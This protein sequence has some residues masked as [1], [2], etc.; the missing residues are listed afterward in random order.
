MQQG[1]NKQECPEPQPAPEKYPIINCHTHI[2]TGDSV[3]PYLAKSIVISPFYK[4]FN[5]QLIFWFFRKRL[6]KKAE[7]VFDGTQ[8]LKARSAFEKEKKYK[9]QFFRQ[10]VMFLLSIYLFAWVIDIL[11]HWFFKMPSSPKWLVS[12]LTNSDQVLHMIYLPVKNGFLQFLV[13]VAVFYFFKPSRRLILTL[14]KKGSSLV[15]SIPTKEIKELY[16]R[17]MTIGRFAFH[18]RQRRTLED[19]EKQYPGNT[20]FVI[21]PM[22]MTYM[23]AGTPPVTYAQ[24]MEELAAIRAKKKNIHPFVFADPR[25]MKE[26]PSYFSYEVK[27]G[28]I[29]L[30]DCFVKKYIDG[31]I[32]KNEK[33]EEVG[34]AR[35]SG[36]KIYPALGYFPFDPLL[37]P[38]WKYAQQENLPIMTHCVRG[39]IHYRGKKDEAWDYHP[40]FRELI[41]KIEPEDRKDTPADYTKLLLA[42]KKNTEFTANFTHPMNY[43]CLLKKE[44]LAHAVQIAWSEADAGTKTKLKALFDF[45]PGENDKDPVVNSGLDE[46]K[47]CFGHYGGDDEWQRYFEKDRFRHSSQLVSRPDTGINFLHKVNNKK[48]PEPSLGKPEQLWKFTDWYSIISSLMLQHD[49]VYADISYILHADAKILPLLKQTLHNDKLRSKVL[50]GTDFFVV[51]NHK[52]DKNMLADMMGGLSEE[53]FDQIARCNPR[54]FLNL[55]MYLADGAASHTPADSGEEEE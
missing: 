27:D 17:Y 14:L 51:R 28:R 29:E 23:D 54:K 33:G 48:P 10:A 19:L 45:T 32:A 20:E 9:K 30:N 26:D 44:F 53:D 16:E 25:R 11:L 3:P 42:Q 38:L 43:V 37:L 55:P 4:I 24:Q 8:N 40:I 2:F 52:T 15:G 22:D 21:L 7:E 12:L 13:L 36:F 39:P 31:H 49:N 46:L 34:F 18:K 5:F 47:L 50:Y 1:S 35:F 41:K 6:S